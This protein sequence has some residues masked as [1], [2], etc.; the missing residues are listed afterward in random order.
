M[1][2]GLL[3]AFGQRSAIGHRYGRHVASR[4]GR[5]CA[6]PYRRTLLATELQPTRWGAVWHATDPDRGT[7]RTASSLSF[8]F[9]LIACP[10]PP[11]QHIHE[12]IAARPAS[13]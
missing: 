6:T 13:S 10:S 4:Q 9:F 7:L 12:C 2:S 8:A 11:L 1:S 3:L 5:P